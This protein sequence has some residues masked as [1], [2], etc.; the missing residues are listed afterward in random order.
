MKK[1]R[2]TDLL[3]SKLSK[4]DKQI[5]LDLFNRINRVVKL[6]R[7]YR[8][9]LINDFAAAAIYYTKKGFTTEDILN[10]LDADKLG[11]FYVQSNRRE[12][13]PLDNAAKIY[14][15]SMSH[16]KMSV[17]RLSA[18]LNSDIEPAIL[19]MALNFTIK[20]FPYFAM[21][22]KKGIFWHYIEASSR[23]FG[24]KIES[25]LPCATMNIARNNAPN[26]RVIYY[27]NRISVEFFHILTDATGGMVFLKSLVAEYLHLLGVN[28]SAVDGVFDIDEEPREEE[29]ANDF[30]KADK[31][32]KLKGFGDKPA[33]QMGG[34]LSRQR[35]TE[36]VHF[37]LN[38][39]ELKNVAKANKTT[40][41]GFIL[42]CVFLAAKAT[43]KQRRRTPKRKLQI[44]VPVNM[45]KFYSSNTL[46]NFSLYCVIR[47]GY[48]EVNDFAGMVKIINEQLAKNASKSEL[49][50]TLNLA[51][52]L[53]KSLRFIPLL[54]KQPIAYLI[55]L[56]LGDKV[57]TT[58]LS[59]LG[60]VTVPE[61]MK[62]Y[63]EKFDFVLSP[64]ITNR[65]ASTITTYK[66]LTI[67]SIT[68]ITRDKR[69]E[70]ELYRLLTDFGNKINVYGSRIHGQE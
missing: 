13:Y 34:R 51:N 66:D 28:V 19:Q 53:V 59:N 44:Q 30:L 54:V 67:I 23:R 20:R 24:I 15:L 5:Y 14:P 47:L 55:Y 1:P 29:W 16:E 35:P 27:N 65:N 45:R 41:T 42:A 7:K 48:N 57:F 8:L 21:T 26:F 12:W 49:D 36:I 6:P 33:L 38:S 18:Y 3:M 61:E 17:F 60:I 25:K 32:H 39:T 40:I 69:F 22:I 4:D 64:P 58:T 2:Q 11:E 63:I 43:I 70:Q 50:K 31:A 52:R 62:D 10:K 37:E 9:R 56:F 46:R 68:K